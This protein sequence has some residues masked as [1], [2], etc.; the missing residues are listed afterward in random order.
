MQPRGVGECIPSR[1]R[2]GG[3]PGRSECRTA[4]PRHR[5][6]RAVSPMS[7]ESASSPPRGFDPPDTCGLSSALNPRPVSPPHPPW[8]AVPRLPTWGSQ[9]PGHRQRVLRGG[10]ALL[11]GGRG[12]GRG[13][14]GGVR[15]AV[16]K[17]A[18]YGICGK[19]GNGEGR[20]EII[21]PE[22]HEGGGEARVESPDSGLSAVHL[23]HPHST[24]RADLQR[25]PPLGR[26]LVRCALH[27]RQAAVRR[28]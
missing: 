7:C 16:K 25:R 13:G 17:G 14:G 19:T 18:E 1:G 8:S 21:N 20:C 15:W 6:G 12:R 2:N 3:S 10:K 27:A 24:Q 5:I 23:R 4:R 11:Q 26:L 28:E 9:H 22:T